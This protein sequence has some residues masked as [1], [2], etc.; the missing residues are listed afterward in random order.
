MWCQPRGRRSQPGPGGRRGQ[1][2]APTRGVHGRGGPLSLMARQP[3]S[4]TAERPP[5]WACAM[6]RSEPEGGGGDIQ[7][8]ETQCGLLDPDVLGS[9]R[10]LRAPGCGQHSPSAFHYF[11]FLLLATKASWPTQRAS[12]SLSDRDHTQGSAC[13][14]REPPVSNPHGL[15]EPGFTGPGVLCLLPAE[16]K[17]VSFCLCCAGRPPFT[18]LSLGCLSARGSHDR[19]FTLR[20]AGML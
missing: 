8:K 14:S 4:V 15:K 11:S 7:K 10:L 17:A 9:R 19:A 6:W 2:A 20:R 3:P 18:G 16:L 12:S 5:P 1:P 13:T